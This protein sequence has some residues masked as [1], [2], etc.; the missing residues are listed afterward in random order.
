MFQGSIAYSAEQ[1]VNVASS[2]RASPGVMTFSNAIL[3]AFVSYNIKS[4]KQKIMQIDKD[5]ASPE[6]A[7]QEI[8][9]AGLLPEEWGGDTPMVEVK[10]LIPLQ[11]ASAGFISLV[12]GRRSN[13]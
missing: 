10:I 3:S 12:F 7:K 6:R 5:G 8:S 11:I 4:F 9:E 1:Y 13:Q 2:F